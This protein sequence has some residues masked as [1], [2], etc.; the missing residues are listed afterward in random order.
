M[1]P[2]KHIPLKGKGQMNMMEMKRVSEE[3]VESVTKSSGDGLVREAENVCRREVEINRRH[4]TS[5]PVGLVRPGSKSRVS[6]QRRQ[7]HG[8]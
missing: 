8:G 7:I 1:G 3:M 2:E 4:P 6:D 5:L